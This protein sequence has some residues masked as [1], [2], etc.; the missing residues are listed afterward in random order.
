MRSAFTSC[1]LRA[2]CESSVGRPGRRPDAARRKSYDEL[3]DLNVRD[4]LVYYRALKADRGR[5]DAYVSS[6]ATASLDV[7]DA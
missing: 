3:L 2:V 4:G 6:L 7:G 5:L 1:L